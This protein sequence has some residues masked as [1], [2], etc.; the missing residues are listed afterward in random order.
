MEKVKYNK[1][2]AHQRYKTDDG[3]PVPG[4]TTVLSVQ[5]KP[6]L[7]DYKKV[8]DCA[9]DIGSISHWLIEC[10]LKRIEPDTSEFSPADF[11][12]AENAMIKFLSWWDKSGMEYISSEQQLVSE[13]ERFGGT[14]DIVA[15]DAGGVLCLIDIKTS[16][17]I[18]DEYWQQVAAYGALWNESAME[19]I[20]LYYIC[21]FGK[22]E[23]D[24]DFEV[25]ERKDL[26]PH[27]AVFRA[28][29]VA[30]YAIKKLKA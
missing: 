3:M 6:A 16:K 27:L 18:Y 15:R 24:S 8:K 22:D 2:R 20:G 1:I 4:V 21:R 10:H 19:K 14:L 5:A 29:L 7:I 11:G 28:F 23:A 26:A 13:K 9:A 12:K 17:G 30:Y 25:Q